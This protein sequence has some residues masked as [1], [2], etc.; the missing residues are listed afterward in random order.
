MHACVC[1]NQ[2]GIYI[3]PMRISYF[4]YFCSAHLVLNHLFFCCYC[5]CFVVVLLLSFTALERL[6]TWQT[7]SG[8]KAFFLYKA[9][10]L[11]HYICHI[12]VFILSCTTGKDLSLAKSCWFSPCHVSYI[13]SMSI[14][15]SIHNPCNL[16]AFTFLQKCSHQGHQRPPCN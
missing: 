9:F 11:T 14:A 1:V 15:T 8:Y 6:N 2:I 13:F 16:S 12:W 3:Y 7:K 10:L 5:C 4:I